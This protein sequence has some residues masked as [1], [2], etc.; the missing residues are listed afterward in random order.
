[1]DIKIEELLAQNYMYE[2]LELCG[3]DDEYIGELYDG[4]DV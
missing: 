4:H 2:E 3:Y 1:M